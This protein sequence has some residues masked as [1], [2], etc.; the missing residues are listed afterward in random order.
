MY[1]C[2]KDGETYQA[3]LHVTFELE[4]KDESGKSE[5]LEERVYMGDVPVMTPRATFIINGAERVIISQLHR[6]PGICFEA[7]KSTTNK[8]LCTLS[9]YS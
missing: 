7:G 5:L 2:L 9:N 8:T 4:I 1:D 3:P 6:T